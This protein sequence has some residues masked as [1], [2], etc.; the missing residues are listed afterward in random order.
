MLCQVYNIT[1]KPV[2]VMRG[3]R[4]G[5]ALFVKLGRVTEWR[6]QKTMRKKSR[7]GFGSTGS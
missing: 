4:I 1:K 5:Q 2:Q 6:E 7:G 3:E